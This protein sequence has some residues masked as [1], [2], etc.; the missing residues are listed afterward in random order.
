MDTVR[1][2]LRYALRMISRSPGFTA[3][4]VL[5]LALGIGANT[6]IFS[7]VNAVLLR[8]LPYVDPGRLVRLWSAYPEDGAERS[9]TSPLDL[10]D[11]RQQNGVF[12]QMAGFPSVRLSGFVLTGS[13]SPAEISTV[14]VTEGFFESLGVA[15]LLG[16]TLAPTDQVDGNNR[17]VV[18][19]H[20]YWQQRFGADA[21][22]VGSTLT[23]NGSPFTVIGVMPPAF[24]YPAADTEMWAPLSLIPDSGVPRRR[25]VRWLQVVARLK[26]GVTLAQAQTEM[27][28]VVG[29]LAKQYPE[30]N[31]RLTG[32]TLRPLHEEMVGDL[33]TA[34][35]TLFAAVVLVLL[36]GCANVAN[37]MLARAEGRHKEVAIRMALGARRR[38]LIRQLLTESLLLTLS[39]GAVGLLLALWGVRVLVAMAPEEIP[40]LSQVGVD[41]AVLGFTTLL[42]LAAGLLFGLV[43][44]LRVA[45]AD[46]H[47]SLKEGP[48]GRRSAAHPHRRLRSLLVVSEVALVVVLAVAAGLLLRSYG[49]LLRVDPGFEPRHLLTLAVTAQSYKYPERP[50]F[51]GFFHDLLQ[52]LEQLPGV[53]SVGMVRPLPL[54]GDTFEGESFTF[55]IDSRPSPPAGHEPGAVMRFVS[56]GYFHT[57]GIPLLAGRDFS[58]RDSARAPIVL[59]VNHTAAERYWPG[60]EP[61]GKSISAGNATG[62]LIIGVVGDVRQLALAQEPMPVIY[63]VYTQVARVGMTLVVRTA[64]DPRSMIGAVRR[65]IWEVDSDQPIEQ[66]APM[67]QVIA[68]SL[69]QPRFSMTLLG[70]FAGLALVLAAVGIYGV[71]SYTVSQQT[72]EIGIR[73]TLGAQGSDLL[74]LVVRRAMSL[75]LTGIA[76]GLAGALAAGHWMASLLFGISAFDPPTFLLATLLLTAVALAASLVPA[77]RAS[78]VDP[79][80]AIRSS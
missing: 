16:R 49:R 57:M 54:R 71:I 51:T 75:A 61:V 67:E 7:V 37:L 36:I 74:R 34:M 29:R 25:G 70:I 5:T 50:Q 10:D 78:R 32:V 63:V 20:A 47:D 28:T 65:T 45:G 62:L 17:V 2:D 9:S 21:G 43:P 30:S 44:A 13:E 18:L 46:L 41:G 58:A 11:W 8:P 4:A 56:P 23:L 53:D 64:A 22:I 12:E 68:D 6:A 15:A 76:I 69:V 52:R 38:R 1:Q 77:L 55:S 26:P 39:G 33:R 73:M 72:H 14:F 27:N 79:L 59:V 31:E 48:L 19:S 66:I 80:I 24:E 3:A 40:M 35:L 60:E 42:T